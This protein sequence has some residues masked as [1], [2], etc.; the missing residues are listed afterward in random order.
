[1]E[2]KMSSAD[3]KT[4]LMHFQQLWDKRSSPKIKAKHTV[5]IWDE[6][7]VEWI[8][9][10]TAGNRKNAMK[11]RVKLVAEYLRTRGLLCRDDTVCDIGSGPGLFVTEFAKTAKHA[12]GIDFSANF[13]EYGRKL[14]TEH[15]A[16]NISF[17]QHN[18]RTLNV[19]DTKLTGAFDLVFASCMPAISGKGVLDKIMKM[20]R[21]MCCNVFYVNIR[22]SLMERISIDVFKGNTQPKH[23]G[24]GFYA[25]FNLLL[26]SGYY[27]ETHYFTIE[28]NKIVKP[29]RKLA[30]KYAFKLGVDTTENAEKIL[31][32]LEK[33]GEME[34]HGICR[35]GSILW[36]VRV[37]NE[38]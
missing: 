12:I 9:G 34:N 21:A 22:D 20:S 15:R 30:E 32:Y 27:P 3:F 35:F 8:E 19:E 38:R 6:I 18:I 4:E 33:N 5:E 17:Q 25:L 29:S 10:L 23:D 14:A 31:R 13:I 28:T 11:E 2:E 36:D 24:S 26:L 16:D 7:A 37:W 1:M